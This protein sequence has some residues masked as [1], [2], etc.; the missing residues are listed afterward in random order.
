MW[1][2]LHDYF[3]EFDISSNFM[4]ELILSKKMIIDINNLIQVFNTCRDNIIKEKGRE[5]LIHKMGLIKTSL[6][7]LI[8]NYYN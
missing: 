4:N 3:I 2:K 6:E 1:N 7:K 5:E 8:D